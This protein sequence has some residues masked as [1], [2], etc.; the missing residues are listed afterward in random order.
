MLPYW[1]SDITVDLAAG[2]T[3]LVTAHGNSVGGRAS[4]TT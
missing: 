1:F 2:K 4:T 3:V